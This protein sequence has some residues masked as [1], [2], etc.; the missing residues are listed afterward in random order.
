MARFLKN[1][2]VRS[3]FRDGLTGF[4]IAKNS[5]H[6]VFLKYL[7]LYYFQKGKTI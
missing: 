1:Y 2:I 7:R 4:I 6:A 5:A 3:G